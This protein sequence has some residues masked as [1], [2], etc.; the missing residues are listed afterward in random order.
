MQYGPELLE[1]ENQALKEENEALTR[2]VELQAKHQKVLVEYVQNAEQKEAKFLERIAA[3][4]RQDALR[5]QR[6]G[7]LQVMTRELES[8]Y[9]EK[10]A[11][12]QR[13]IQELEVE[14][15]EAKRPPRAKPD[16]RRTIGGYEGEKYLDSREEIAA[17]VQAEIAAKMELADTRIELARR[18]VA[19]KEKEL[20]LLKEENVKL[21]GKATGYQ[22]QV[23][24]L[25]AQLAHAKEQIRQQGEPSTQ[26]SESHAFMATAQRGGRTVGVAWQRTRTIRHVHFRE[27]VERMPDV[28]RMSLRDRSPTPRS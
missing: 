18:M 5:V 13:R 11:R 16:F 3:L 28:G 12:T 27:D 22:D 15:F 10:E 23:I 26:E 25:R 7:E 1:E 19:A 17:Q 9:Q 4:E 2:Q 21:K 24:D 20:E 6:L 14:L 8:K